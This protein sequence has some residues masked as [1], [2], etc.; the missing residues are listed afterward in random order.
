[1]RHAMTTDLSEVKATQDTAG[2]CHGFF[3]M[4]SRNK[5]APYCG[6]Y[7]CLVTVLM[8]SW[9][10]HV[11]D[12]ATHHDKIQSGVVAELEEELKMWE[13]KRLETERIISEAIYTI[14]WMDMNDGNLGK[15]ESH[16]TPL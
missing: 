15:V 9:L 12:T 16:G 7:R 6:Q 3:D 13:S 14:A 10:L 8:L 1:M 2:H 11:A 5:S 4:M